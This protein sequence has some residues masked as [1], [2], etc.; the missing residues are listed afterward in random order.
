MN[1]QD[2]HNE[3]T[4]TSEATPRAP[5]DVRKRLVLEGMKK[6]MDAFFFEVSTV[7]FQPM[8]RQA[9]EQGRKSFTILSY[10]NSTQYGPEFWEEEDGFRVKIHPF[11][12]GYLMRGPHR[13]E[14]EGDFFKD[15]GIE[16][17]QDRLDKH[18]APFQCKVNIRKNSFRVNLVWD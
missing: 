16:K 1:I 4:R 10:S 9:A 17:L 15:N 8:V 2:L 11:Y 7:D 3:I 12:L 13:Y 5:P 6:T 14:G 18:F